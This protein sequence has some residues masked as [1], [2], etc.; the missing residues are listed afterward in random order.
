MQTLLVND[1][2]NNDIDI[3]LNT[4]IEYRAPGWKFFRTG[5]FAMD[6][7]G[8][9]LFYCNST[10]YMGT[11]GNIRYNGVEYCLRNNRNKMFLSLR[12]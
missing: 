7:F 3:P 8:N 9:R 1:Y 10:F 6:S 11:L 4:R 12:L 5:Y 2:N